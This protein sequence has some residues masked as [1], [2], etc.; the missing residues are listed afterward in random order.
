MNETLLRLVDITNIA[1]N[2]AIEGFLPNQIP[3]FLPPTLNWRIPAGIL[4]GLV[5]DF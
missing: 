3:A 1:I 2:V 4:C 5:L